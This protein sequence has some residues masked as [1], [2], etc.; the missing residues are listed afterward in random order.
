MKRDLNTCSS[1]SAMHHG[2]RVR[3]FFRRS[4]TA[5]QRQQH[6]LESPRTFFSNIIITIR[7]Q[8]LSVSSVQHFRKRVGKKTKKTEQDQQ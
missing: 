8:N 4:T 5:E 1:Q 3:V 2:V 6:I 7:T